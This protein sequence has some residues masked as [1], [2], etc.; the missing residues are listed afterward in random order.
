MF[1][2][3]CILH[4]GLLCAWEFSVSFHL[5]G[6]KSIY[7]KNSR[8][9]KIRLFFFPCANI[10]VAWLLFP[11]GLSPFSLALPLVYSK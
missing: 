5:L 1:F 6:R 4:F 10:S 9:K 11:F 8:K 2:V 7:K 3:C